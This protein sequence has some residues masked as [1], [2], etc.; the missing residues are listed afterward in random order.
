MDIDQYYEEIEFVEVD[1]R[2]INTFGS[3]KETA[4]SVFRITELDGREFKLPE[5]IKGVPQ[6][7]LCF[8]IFPSF[9]SLFSH[10]GR[11][12]CMD[13]LQNKIESSHLVKVN[14]QQRLLPY[15]EDCLQ[16]LGKEVKQNEDG[17]LYVE[18]EAAFVV[19][20][21]RQLSVAQITKYNLEEWYPSIAALNYKF[22][23][24]ES[25]L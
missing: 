15:I 23:K 17:S 19:I 3:F 6:C 22:S 7:E 1:S 24:R 11:T 10:Q 12:S 18:N 9:S 20:L 25:D 8:R 4:K 14:F 5:L 13:D 16:S 2:E 21:L